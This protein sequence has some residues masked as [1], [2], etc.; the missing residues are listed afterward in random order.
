MFCGVP[1]GTLPLSTN[2]QSGAARSSILS[3]R[4]SISSLLGV[5]PGKLMSVVSCVQPSTILIPTRVQP[6]SR[7]KRSPMPLRS[8]TDSNKVSFSAPRKPVAK[9]SIPA[10]APR[11]ARKQATFTPLPPTCERLSATRFTWPAANP[12]MLNV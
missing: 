4:S 7:T 2:Q 12:G 11:S 5:R 6:E 1:A 10:S 8:N 9:T 3:N